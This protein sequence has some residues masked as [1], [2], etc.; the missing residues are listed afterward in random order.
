G[1]AMA[2]KD[3]FNEFTLMI[4]ATLGA[5]FIG[6]YPEGV[7]VMLFYTVGELFQ[8]SAVLKARKNIKTLLDVRPDKATVLRNGIAFTLAPEAVS[9]GETIQAKAGE[10]I[11]LDGVLLSPKGSFNTSALTGESVPRTLREGETVL[12]GMVNLNR[13]VEIKVEKK[14]ADSSLARVLEMVQEATSRKAKTELFIRSFARVYTPIVFALALAITVIP[15]FIVPDY[16]FADWLYRAL[17]FLV[18][19]CPCA[20]VVSIPLSYFGG[21]GA[22]SRN[23]ILFKGANYLDMIAKANTVVIDKTGTLTEGIF[24]VQEVKSVYKGQPEAAHKGGGEVVYQGQ[25]TLNP[26]Q[27]KSLDPE[28]VKSLDPEKEKMAGYVAALESKSNHPIAKAILEHSPNLVPGNYSVEEAKEIAGRGM[29]GLVNGHV[30]L[31]GNSKLMEMH[32]VE[33]DPEVDKIKETVVLAAIDNRYAGY[34]VIADKVKADS[35]STIRRLKRLGVHTT[36]M[37]SGD[38]SSIV[39]EVAGKLGIDQAYGDLLPGDKVKHIE[40]LKKDPSNVV[41]FAGDGIND[42]PALALSDVGIAMG[43]MGSDAA[44][45]VADVVIQTDQPSKI[46]TAIQV[47]RSTRVIVIQNIVFALGVKFLIMLLGAFGIATMWEAV[48]ADVGV[49]LIAILNAVRILRKKFD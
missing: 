32:D 34:L 10:K 15:S 5:F 17:V 23:G 2:K 25:E 14:Y 20:L 11:P 44:I 1:S 8:E 3:F 36:V 42:A 46:A 4:V 13:V 35:K 28:Q 41:A 12:A 31:A 21:I 45:E 30:V 33:Y 24:E 40:E 38:K 29:K 22:A 16:V 9:I 7:A 19:S 47:A 48:F 18:I 43:G 6:E 49:S 26:E 39:Q 37:L 27:M